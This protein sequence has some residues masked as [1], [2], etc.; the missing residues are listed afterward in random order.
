LVIA[1]G[2]IVTVTKEFWDQDK[3]K[4]NGDDALGISADL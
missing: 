2:Q 4:E 1:F 3:S